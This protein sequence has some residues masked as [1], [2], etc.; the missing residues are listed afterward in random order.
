MANLERI[1]S[2]VRHVKANGLEIITSDVQVVDTDAPDEPCPDFYVHF[3]PPS[4]EGEA[5]DA[6]QCAHDLAVFDIE[7]YSPFLNTN[8]SNLSPVHSADVADVDKVEIVLDDGGAG[9]LHFSEGNIYQN[10]KLSVNVSVHK[11]YD[12]SLSRWLEYD[13]DY[14]PDLL[15]NAEAF[16]GLVAAWSATFLVS[17][18][19]GYKRAEN[20]LS[21]IF[22]PTYQ[23]FGSLSDYQ[24]NY[25]T[26]LTV[27]EH[28]CPIGSSPTSL[29][30]AV[31]HGVPEYNS[32]DCPLWDATYATS[33]SIPSDSNPYGQWIT[34]HLK[35]ILLAPESFTDGTIRGGCKIGHFTT[36]S[37]YNTKHRIVDFPIKGFTYAMDNLIL[38]TVI[39]D[40]RYHVD[41]R[42]ALVGLDSQPADRNVGGTMITAGNY[43]AIP[44]IYIYVPPPYFSIELVGDINV[45]VNLLT[46]QVKVRY[47]IT[48]VGQVY[49][50]AIPIVFCRRYMKC[51]DIAYYALEGGNIP[52]IAIDNPSS[53]TF[54]EEVRS[55]AAEDR[56]GYIPQVSVSLNAD[57]TDYRGNSPTGAGTPVT[58]PSRIICVVPSG[59]TFDAGYPVLTTDQT[60]P[61]SSGHEKPIPHYQY[62]PCLT[63]RKTELVCFFSDRGQIKMSR[64]NLDGYDLS[65]GGHGWQIQDTFTNPSYCWM[66]MDALFIGEDVYLVG[67]SEPHRFPIFGYKTFAGNTGSYPCISGYETLG[68][69]T[70][71]FTVKGKW[72]G[73][74]WDWTNPTALDISPAPPDISVKKNAKTFKIRQT[75]DGRFRLVFP[76]PQEAVATDPVPYVYESHGTDGDA[77]MTFERIG[78]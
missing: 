44:P 69:I 51:T 26:A 7:A 20:D 49:N 52:T 41:R 14:M 48:D 59:D 40:Y 43:G 42:D 22:D 45:G 30:S 78:V 32:L 3:D 34:L 55:D 72:N 31:V 15:L 28:D 33:D 37:R 46:L 5:D 19:G 60:P 24:E 56:K 73:T 77:F 25:P 39:E 63:K 23:N 75:D 2:N 70:G 4:N 76:R 66:Y 35:D 38:T 68:T 64:N 13:Y 21:E 12:K 18:L 36:E 57:W 11:Y 17:G 27:M 10:A 74:S 58:F 50:I 9:S 65:D 62:A 29:R 8:I 6:T 71:L 61:Y 47:L 67:Y 16:A 54:T 53:E 1:Q